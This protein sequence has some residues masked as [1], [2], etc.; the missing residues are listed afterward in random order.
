VDTTNHLQE[1]IHYHRYER[2]FIMYELERVLLDMEK[3][4]TEFFS[5]ESM[6][7]RDFYKHRTRLYEHFNELRFRY[8]TH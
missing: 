2:N 3:L 4:M 5:I 6:E 7:M 8:T 1:C